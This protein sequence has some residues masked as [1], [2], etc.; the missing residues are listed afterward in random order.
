M[1]KV[2][3]KH[4]ARRGKD[5][6]AQVFDGILGVEDGIYMLECASDAVEARIPAVIDRRYRVE[7]G[8]YV[9]EER[10]GAG[11]S[12]VLSNESWVLTL[13]DPPSLKLRRGKEADP[14]SPRLRHDRGRS[15]EVGDCR[16]SVSDA[17]LAGWRFTE[18]PYN[19]CPERI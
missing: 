9:L 4:G 11:G 10:A 19:D 15:T 6:A 12:C 18:T 1:A 16:A 5:G 3:A 2:R 7:R 8:I 14:P 13:E 17:S